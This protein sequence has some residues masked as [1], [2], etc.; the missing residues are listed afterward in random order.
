MQT[1]Y[2]VGVP[3]HKMNDEEPIT[4]PAEEIL[5]DVIHKCCFQNKFVTY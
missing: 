1:T 4:R 3:A 5:L 2:S